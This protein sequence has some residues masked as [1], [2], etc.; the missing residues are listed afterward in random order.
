MIRINNLKDLYLEDFDIFSK[1]NR[2]KKKKRD[3]E[4][5]KKQKLNEKKDGDFQG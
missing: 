4:K 1:P 3:G 5:R 2:T